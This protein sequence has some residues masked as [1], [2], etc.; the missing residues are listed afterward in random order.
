M[1]GILIQ[2]SEVG[3]FRLRCTEIAMISDVYRSSRV[4]YPDANGR[5]RCYGSA[6][7]ILT[8]FPLPLVIASP[9]SLRAVWLQVWAPSALI[10]HANDTGKG[11][12]DVEQSKASPSTIVQYW[13]IMYKSTEKAMEDDGTQVLVS[14][15]VHTFRYLPLPVAAACTRQDQGDG[16]DTVDARAV[17][18]SGCLNATYPR[19]AV[20]NLP[21][22]LARRIH[23]NF[24]SANPPL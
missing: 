9:P 17:G 18:H 24:I 16:K 8:I 14:V 5:P 19:R 6:P 21:S 2:D 13:H 15:N 7:P 23:H 3:C 10:T 11:F 20:S 4:Y 22:T 12:N 1:S